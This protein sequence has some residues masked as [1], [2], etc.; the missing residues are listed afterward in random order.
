MSYTIIVVV[1]LEPYTVTPPRVTV[2]TAKNNQK[3]RFHLYPSVILHWST[4]TV[5]F[6]AGD[7]AEK[8]G[9]AAALPKLSK[10]IDADSSDSLPLY[11]LAVAAALLLLP[12]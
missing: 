8:Q 5:A 3:N 1:I 11:T 6:L 9:M 10:G 2:Y 12:K 4:A 7:G